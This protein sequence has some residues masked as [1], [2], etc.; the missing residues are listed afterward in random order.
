VSKVKQMSDCALAV[1]T[2][3]STCKAT[4]WLLYNL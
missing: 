2:S 4:I 1:L 3:K